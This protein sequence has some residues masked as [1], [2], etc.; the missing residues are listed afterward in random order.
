MDRT[1]SMHNEIAIWVEIG[2]FLSCEVDWIGTGHCC[3]LNSWVQQVDQSLKVAESSSSWQHCSVITMCRALA[4]GKD[5]QCPEMWGMLLGMPALCL[6]GVHL[7]SLPHRHSCCSNTSSS[8]G[9]SPLYHPGELHHPYQHAHQVQRQSPWGTNCQHLVSAAYCIRL[10][11]CCTPSYTVLVITVHSEIHHMGRIEREN[12]DCW[13]LQ[14][15]R[16]NTFM[17]LIYS[18]M[19]GENITREKELE[20]LKLCSILYTILCHRW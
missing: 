20:G 10:A 11:I 15:I 18:E 17:E 5:Y 9:R 16:M 3:S 2:R 6:A 4:V 14:W 1:N 13:L 8:Q 19:W 7:Q 12:V